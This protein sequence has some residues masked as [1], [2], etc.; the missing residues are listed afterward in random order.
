LFDANGIFSLHLHAH[1]QPT[2]VAAAAGEAVRYLNM[3]W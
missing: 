1:L 2:A 3:L